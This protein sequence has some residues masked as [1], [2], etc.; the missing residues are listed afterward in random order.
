MPKRIKQAERM[1][2][3]D[4]GACRMSQCDFDIIFLCKC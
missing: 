1:I 3:M 4:D 2:V